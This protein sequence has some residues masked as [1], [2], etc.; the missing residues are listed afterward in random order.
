MI[1][2]SSDRKTLII[3]QFSTYEEYMEE[4]RIVTERGLVADS[5]YGMNIR[6]PALRGDSDRLLMVEYE[7]FIADVVGATATDDWTSLAAPRHRGMMNV[8]FL[9]GHVN[10]VHPDEVDP[11]VL[12]LH[13][14]LWRPQTDPKLEP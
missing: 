4:V 7:S 3:H 12:A 9:D 14:D 5:S 1:E 8:A 2:L 13:N 6:A 10:S 11:R